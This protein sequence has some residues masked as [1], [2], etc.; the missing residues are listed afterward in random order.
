M[1]QVNLVISMGNITLD[2][3]NEAYRRI[4]KEEE[5]RSF[6]LH[7]ILYITVNP[8]LIVINLLYSPQILWFYYP[9]IG[10]GFGLI[11]HYLFTFHWIDKILKEKEAKAEYFIKEKSR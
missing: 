10:W 2:E 6:I 8:L 5:K 7:L 4:I 1:K 9:L 3:Y 11:M